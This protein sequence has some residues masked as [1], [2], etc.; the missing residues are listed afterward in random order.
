[1][2]NTAAVENPSRRQLFS[3]LFK[4]KDV[5]VAQT[6]LQ[7]VPA[8]AEHTQ[9]VLWAALGLAE[10]N[11]L[12]AGDDGLIF[13]FDGEQW[14]QE[15]LGTDLPIHAMALASD[16]RVYAVGWA[17]IICFRDAVVNT[18]EE[19][20]KG[21]WHYV[22]G[23]RRPVS[24]EKPSVVTLVSTDETG[25]AEVVPKAVMKGPEEKVAR[26]KANIQALD[27][28]E[29][30]LPLFDVDAS[31]KG[32]VWAVGDQGRVTC[33]REGLWQE[34]DAQTQ[35]NLRSVLV[36]QDDSVMIGGAN[37]VVKHL[38]DE[39][40]HGIET[41]TDCHIVSMAQT[42]EGDV[43]AVGGLYKSEK[44]GF[45]GCIF[46]Y[47]NGVWQEVGA[48]IDL[49]R[50]RRIRCEGENLIIVGD[51]GSAYCWTPQGVAQLHTSSR[52]DLHDII[53]F[54][55]RSSIICGDGGSVLLETSLTAK[56][57]E[58]LHQVKAQSLWQPIFKN[59]IKQT[60]RGCFTFPDGSAIAVGDGG[61]TVHV[62]AD[63]ATLKQVPLKVNL[64]D[65]WGSSPRNAFA[66]GDDGCIF[67]YDGEQWCCVHQ[68]NAPTLLSI[69]GFGP[70]DI[71]AVGDEGVILRYDGLM[72]RR[73]ESGTKSELYHIWGHDSN[74]I[75]VASAGG[76]VLRWNGE[77][78]RSFYVGV[79]HDLYGVWGDSLSSLSV[80]GIC[81]TLLTLQNQ[82]WHKQFAGVRTDLHA[83]DGLTDPHSADE[84]VYVVGSSGTVLRQQG[85]EWLLEDSGV[86]TTLQAV[87]VGQDYVYAAGASGLVLRRKR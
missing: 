43:Y 7:R 22:Q 6:G 25:V 13:H 11:Y 82:A 32:D 71:Y 52:Y 16:G 23:G 49:P 58:S 1:M 38:I 46:H 17:G 44:G 67:H 54:N 74:H 66:V 41:A 14:Q 56:E 30:T 34:Q 70:H 15:A 76:S 5:S 24:V 26:A 62:Q 4:T 18:E 59:E 86:E 69:T 72:W 29:I 61:Y 79:D 75:L 47:A 51:H 73:V 83:I 77:N 42:P 37:G 40:W 85:E 55:N 19:S 64:H 50:L 9:G 31:Q 87:A 28:P 45:V 39:Q 48:D 36:L 78:W 80:V 35:V 65:V 81:G 57:V 2:A 53:C 68:G 8:I 3:R 12:V 84:S 63:V 10:D 20:G 60:L 33:L 27:N 21:Q